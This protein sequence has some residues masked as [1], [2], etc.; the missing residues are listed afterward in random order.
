MTIT[1]RLYIYIFKYDDCHSHQRENIYIYNI[2][3]YILDFL[4]CSHDAFFAGSEHILNKFARLQ[5]FGSCTWPVL[6]GGGRH[7]YAH[8]LIM[9]NYTYKFYLKLMSIE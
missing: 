9:Y 2:Y 1:D 8:T 3:I 4:V 7:K 6:G 5:G